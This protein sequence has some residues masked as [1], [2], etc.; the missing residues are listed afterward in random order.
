ME[1]DEQYLLDSKRLDMNH[2]CGNLEY[3]MCGA[4]SEAGIAE[5]RLRWLLL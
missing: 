2:D 4:E 1:N 5:C 3:S